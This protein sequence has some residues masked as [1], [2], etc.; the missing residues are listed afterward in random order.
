MDF[1]SCD[2]ESIGRAQGKVERQH[3][4][5]L[6]KKFEQ[7]KLERLNGYQGV[8]FYAKNLDDTTDE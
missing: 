6:K 5:E 2:S 3:Q 8:N 1:G 7:L 4:R